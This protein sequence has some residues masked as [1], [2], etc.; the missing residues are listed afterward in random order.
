MGKLIVKEG[1]VLYKSDTNNKE[2]K[3]QD[4]S[5]KYWKNIVNK[6]KQYLCIDRDVEEYDEDILTT[7]IIDGELAR[8]E[9]IKRNVGKETKI[10]ELEKKLKDIQTELN[11]LKLN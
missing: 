7:F 2:F 5:D 9:F 11:K 1:Q 4:I 8:R 3:L 6:Y 10:Q